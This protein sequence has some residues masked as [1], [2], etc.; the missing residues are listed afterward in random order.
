MGQ[1]NMQA[2][3]K[4][5]SPSRDSDRTPKP[6]SPAAGNGLDRLVESDANS[7]DQVTQSDIIR[8]GVLEKLVSVHKNGRR[9]QEWAMRQVVITHGRILLTFEGDNLVREELSLVEIEELQEQVDRENNFGQESFSSKLKKKGSVRNGQPSAAMNGAQEAQHDRA[10]G[11]QHDNSIR[12]GCTFRI[13]SETYNRNMYLRAATP[14]DRENWISD[15]SEAIEQAQIRR[16]VEHKQ[17]LLQRTRKF[18]GTRMD[19]RTFQIIMGCI[20]IIN[21]GLNIM[22]AEIKPGAKTTLAV[23]LDWID[24]CFTIFYVLELALTL[25]VHWW[26]DFLNNGW[27]VFDALCVSIS[28]GTAV[29]A[30]LS[31]TSGGGMSVVRSVR[32]FK[33]VRLFSRLKS[34]Q[35]VVLAITTTVPGLANT[36]ILYMVVNSIYAVI[37]TQVYGDLPFNYFDS[38]SAAILTMVQLST[39]DGWAT[40]IVR[41]VLEAGAEIENFDA[42]FA[43]FFFT[44]Y[45]FVVFVV[46]LNLAVAVLLDGFLLAIRDFHKDEIE[47]ESL[48]DYRKIAH[49][50]DPLLATFANFH[51]EEHLGMMI[52]RFFRYIDVDGSGAISFSELKAGLERLDIQPRLYFTYEDFVALT[53]DLAYVNE[54]EDI[55]EEGFEACVRI[56]MQGYAFR[57][58]AHRMNEA[59]K[60]GDKDRSSDCLAFKVLM[61]EIQELKQLRSEN[62]STEAIDNT[63]RTLEGEDAN[64]DTKTTSRQVA[65]ENG[66]TKESWNEKFEMIMN[67]VDALQNEVSTIRKFVEDGGN[68]ANV[69]ESSTKLRAKSMKSK[70][71]GNSSKLLNSESAPSSKPLRLHLRLLKAKVNSLDIKILCIC[72]H[73]C[74]YE[75]VETGM[76]K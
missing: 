67:K 52:T 1:R 40:D 25:F 11:A 41:P 4:L 61:R 71:A 7:L 24:L 33:I 12:T 26:R 50:L 32:I 62:T 13:Y 44:S 2:A 76:L 58:A 18:L 31:G 30:N 47:E 74:L 69:E 36:F 46:L 39:G 63:D 19:S 27:S 38:F 68:G 28:V 10:Q 42:T 23:T 8:Q 15:L 43:S 20:L 34:L 21:F 55:T 6:L 70:S 22:E 60:T 51:S 57:I 66:A 45:M 5:E 49:N 14:G 17:S 59:Q 56:E 16:E 53:C 72:S 64:M 9:V 48:K 75:F 65:S 35:R 3:A 37:A 73:F 29:Y 54:D